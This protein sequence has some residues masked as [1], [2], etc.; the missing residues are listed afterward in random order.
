MLSDPQPLII[1]Q[2][3]TIIQQTSDGQDLMFAQLQMQMAQQ[4]ATDQL[5]L[6]QNA[7]TQNMMLAQ[8]QMASAQ[9]PVCV[10]QNIYV[11][12]SQNVDICNV[13]ENNVTAYA[14]YGGTGEVVT[15]AD[16]GYGT[17]ATET[18]G[19]E[20]V[21][22][23]EGAAAEEFYEVEYEEDATGEMYEADLGR[24]DTELCF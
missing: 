20:V 18:A 12:Q 7:D 3:Q 24:D 15:F 1:E 21:Y 11:N 22:V 23:D 17:Y 10:E 6:Q 5:L 2:N 16:V 14:D 13:Q 19:E 8:A 9:Q 4:S